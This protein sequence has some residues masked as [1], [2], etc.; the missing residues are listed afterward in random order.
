MC[1]GTFIFVAESELVEMIMST[2]N[3]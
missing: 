1:G 2:T 3:L